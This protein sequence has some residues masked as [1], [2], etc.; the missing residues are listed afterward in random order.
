MNPKK[1]VARIMD[2]KWNKVVANK[3]SLEDLK[4]I[5]SG[6]LYTKT[7]NRIEQLNIAFG[8]ISEDRIKKKDIYI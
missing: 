2:K 3:I 6:T 8:K 7:G 4:I 1:L 5:R